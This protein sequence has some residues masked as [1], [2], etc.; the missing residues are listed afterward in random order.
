M[1]QLV[2]GKSATAEGIQVLSKHLDNIT[3]VLFAAKPKDEASQ[4]LVAECL[5][6]AATVAPS[7]IIPELHKRASDS[8]T[9]VRATA[10]NSLCYLKYDSPNAVNIYEQL[11]PIIG[12]FLKLIGDKELI[13][14]DA[15]INGAGFVIDRA[16]ELVRPVL[17]QHTNEIYTQ[18]ARSEFREI[19][20]GPY[21]EYVDNTL[22]GRDVV[23]GILL[24]LF[25]RAPE[26]IDPHKYVQSV[27]AAY[28]HDAKLRPQT[29]DILVT[30]NLILVRLSKL[31]PAV[32]LSS[33]IDAV[34]PIETEVKKKVDTKVKKSALQAIAAICKI[35][36]W[37]SANTKFTEVVNKVVKGDDKNKQRFDQLMATR[38]LTTL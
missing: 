13:V 1:R 32:V 31:A 2:I 20:Y 15:A 5:G 8:D 35:N 29:D 4:N 26:V 33:L 22:K 7:K 14:R 27:L 28:R 21:K 30:A 25:D 23:F 36:N 18:A 11:K 34:G 16:I 9:S 6:K 37:E 38:D 10:V 17:K 24:N 19:D 3:P 12:D